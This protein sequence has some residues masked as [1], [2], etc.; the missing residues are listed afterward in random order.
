MKKYKLFLLTAVLVLGLGACKYSFIE[1]T[2]LPPINGG[3]NGEETVFF[4]TDVVPIFTAN[5]IACHATR[6]P[7]LT[8]SEAYTS[9]ANAKYVNVTTPSDSYIIQHV[10]PNSTVHTQKHLTAAQAQTI[11]TWIAEGA[12]NN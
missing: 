9:I 3:G 10:G 7:V 12:K 2:V 11:L 5:C 8:S 1:E 6:N 4:A